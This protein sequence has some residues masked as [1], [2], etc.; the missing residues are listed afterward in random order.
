MLTDLRSLRGEEY[1]TQ[2]CLWIFRDDQAG[3]SSPVS[4]VRGTTCQGRVDLW[5]SVTY[6]YEWSTWESRVFTSCGAR[7]TQADD[8]RTKTYGGFEISFSPHVKERTVGPHFEC[9]RY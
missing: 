5:K 1:V 4:G 9:K 8:S 7:I 3:H 2:P 6:I